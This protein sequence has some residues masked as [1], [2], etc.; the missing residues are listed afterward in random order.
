MHPAGKGLN[1]DDEDV[2]VVLFLPLLSLD[3]AWFG[4]KISVVRGSSVLRRES[5]A[6]SVGMCSM[7]GSKEPFG[8]AFQWMKWAGDFGGWFVSCSAIMSASSSCLCLFIYLFVC[9]CLVVD[10]FPT[11]CFVMLHNRSAAGIQ[12]HNGCGCGECTQILASSLTSIL[13]YWIR[14][15]M[16]LS[17]AVLQ[18][19]DAAVPSWCRERCHLSAQCPITSR[20]RRTTIAPTSSAPQWAQ[21]RLNPSNRSNACA[22]V[23]NWQPI[24]WKPAAVWLR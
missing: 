20:N 15:E 11:K 12:R 19:P 2:D 7:T 18:P 22:T 5:G 17:L 21:L 4:C 10:L 13:G 8:T 6:S 1:E 23:V 9:A 24:S 3:S 14:L 16:C